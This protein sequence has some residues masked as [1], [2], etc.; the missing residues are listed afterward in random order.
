MQTHTLPHYTS[1]SCCMFSDMVASL[2]AI[3]GSGVSDGRVGGGGGGSV[4]E[5]IAISSPVLHGSRRHSSTSSLVIYGTSSTVSTHT[6]SSSSSS[7]GGL[8]GSSNS[9]SSSSNNSSKNWPSRQPVN[10]HFCGVRISMAFNLRNHVR[11]CKL[12]PSQHSQFEDATSLYHLHHPVCDTVSLLSVTPN[13]IAAPNSCVAPT[14]TPQLHQHFVAASGSYNSTSQAPYHIL[15]A[16][17]AVTCNDP[18][19]ILS[20]SA[21][22]AT[23]ST[24]VITAT[25]TTTTTTTAT[26]SSS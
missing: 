5:T 22:A 13:I 18:A 23:T 20:G 15:N 24:I 6:N 21:S 8:S 1:S 16:A 19:V 10:C 4:V 25:A 26:T 17:I 14:R 3:V 2:S 11:R 12:R 9:N 7:G